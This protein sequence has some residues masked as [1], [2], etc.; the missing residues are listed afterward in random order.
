MSSRISVFLG[1]FREP[2]SCWN[3]ILEVGG[4]KEQRGAVSSGPEIKQAGFLS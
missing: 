2:Y 4:A 1:N 3:L